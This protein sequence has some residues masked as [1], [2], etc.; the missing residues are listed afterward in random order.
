MSSDADS[1]HDADGDVWTDDDRADE[2]ARYLNHLEDEFGTA[3]LLMPLDDEGKAPWIKGRAGLET[4]KAADALYEPEEAIQ[5]FRDGERGFAI[6]AGREEHRT[7]EIVFIDHDDR[8]AF[9]TPT[10]DP[11]LEVT[12]GSGRGEHETYRNDPDDPVRN[13]RVNI[14]GDEVGEVRTENWYV[15]APGSIHPSGGVYEIT[16]ERPIA[17][18]SDADLTDDHR[19]AGG[20][21]ASQTDGGAVSASQNV[22]P[23]D[24]DTSMLANDDDRV[25]AVMQA[26]PELND[27][28]L[29]THRPSDRSDA[30]W[31]YV[32]ELIKG[33]VNEERTRTLL[34]SP[35]HT[36]AHESR[37][38]DYWTRTWSKALA[39][40]VS[41]GNLPEPTEPGRGEG[42]SAGH[43]TGLTEDSDG[44]ATV[45][46]DD[47]DD[48]TYNPITNF[49]MS[50]NS[51]VTL[52]DGSERINLTVLPSGSV[53]DYEVTVC[54][55]VF[56]EPRA[57]KSAVVTSRATKFNGGERELGLLR[58]VVGFT[59]SPD[60][61]G[62]H[63]MGLHENEFVLPAGVLTADG[64]TDDPETVYVERQ[65][66]FERKVTL[67]PD[68]SDAD[69]ETVREIIELLPR[70]R[71]TERFLPAVGW[72]YAMPLAPLI[73]EWRREIPVLSVTGDTGAGKTSTLEAVWRLFGA[74]GEPFSAGDTTFTMLKTLSSS[75]ALPV[76]YDEYKPSDM[77]DRRRDTFHDLIRK[78]TRGGVEQRGTPDQ[79][80][81]LYRLRPP[82]VVSGEQRFAGPAEQRRSV[83]TTFRTDDTEP[84]SETARAF[85]R[86]GEL[87]SDSHATMYLQWVLGVPHAAR[88]EAWEQA[89]DRV[90]TVVE[91]YGLTEID[92]AGET[93]L[94][95]VAF[96][97]GL[98]R[99]FA[100]YVDADVSFDSDDVEV[101]LRYAGKQ[102]GDDGGRVNHLDQ[103][104]GLLSLA[105]SDMELEE[106][107]EFDPMYKGKQHEEIRINLSRAYPKVS[108]YVRNHGLE[109][110]ELLG[111]NDYNERIKEAAERSDSYVT[112]Y[113]QNSP[114][115]GRAFGIYADH[116]ERDIDEFTRD[117][118]RGKASDK[119]KTDEDLG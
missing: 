111:K 93:A 5:A 41:E 108:R 88:K 107:K 117:N 115:V 74:D 63:H 53:D 99:A 20:K 10:G 3:P 76:W 4:D 75:N 64:W 46:Y 37:N 14:D 94:Q 51:Y 43:V 84:N 118:F 61:K 82:T 58:D 48:V 103:F 30:E 31:V 25:R 47:D 87:E 86:L 92:S 112:C 16:N 7:S 21:T 96:G 15:V 110:I 6:Y 72:F 13:A 67:S 116:A 83:M 12:S 49:T 57:F 35:H 18:L 69:R 62:T 42:D 11:T 60:R 80:M 24:V 101:A 40:V 114:P 78:T 109:D 81:N 22:H 65:T 59:D 52:P 29:G 26:H 27:Y 19:P 100:S 68:D 102:H 2:L 8:E 66:G 89:G 9:P 17:T 71:D 98:Y 91:T 73:R 39:E 50:V 85:R 44:Y 32:K 79:D 38:S 34:E 97:L 1:P 45:R 70:T 105:A 106:G 28:L 95:T 113:Q 33:G 23:V 104:V 55:T 54:P 119:Y 90:Q 36:R 77:A 56:N